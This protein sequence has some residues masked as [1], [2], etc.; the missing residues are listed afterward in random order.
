MPQAAVAEGMALLVA[1]RYPAMA[2]DL[3]AVAVAGSILIP[4]VGPFLTRRSLG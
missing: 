3:V 1:E 2:D 4:T